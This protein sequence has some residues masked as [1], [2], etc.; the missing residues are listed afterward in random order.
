MQ[1]FQK[2]KQ[3]FIVLFIIWI[4]FFGIFTM[5]DAA[6][7]SGSQGQSLTVSKTTKLNPEGDNVTI[8]G[9]NFSLDKGIYVALCYAPKIGENPTPCG[10][11][12]GSGNTNANWISSNPP[13][14]GVGLAK[15]FEDVESKGFFEVSL[16]V[17]STI[18]DNFDCLDRVKAPQGC[19]IVAKRDHVAITD[20]SLDVVVPVSFGD[21][22]DLF[23][24]GDNNLPKST[25]FGNFE[26]EKAKQ[27]EFVA[28]NKNKLSKTGF[29]STDVFLATILLFSLAVFLTFV[30]RKKHNNFEKK[31]ES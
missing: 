20:R 16:Q 4:S 15:P 3:S 11:E 25:E 24:N 27:K 6:T 29:T 21:T 10:G 18:G 30:L 26:Q 8:V 31:K 19:A 2:I 17:K 14:Y 1:K 12:A 7:I 13:K 5:A 22:D 9:K 28:A 23:V